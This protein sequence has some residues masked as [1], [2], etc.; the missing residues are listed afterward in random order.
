MNEIVH[1]M[2]VVY[3]I[4]YYTQYTCKGKMNIYF[5][6]NYPNFIT[7]FPQDLLFIIH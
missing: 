6:M 5:K 7:K 2:P 3:T 4:L 1:D